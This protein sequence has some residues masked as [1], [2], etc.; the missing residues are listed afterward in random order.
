MLEKT[1][2]EKDI[3]A[4]KTHKQYKMMFR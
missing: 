3:K 4:V 2:D 1:Y